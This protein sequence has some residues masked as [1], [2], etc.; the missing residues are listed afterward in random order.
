MARALVQA[1]AY[2]AHRDARPAGCG[3]DVGDRRVHGV[4]P[5]VVGLP[6]CDLIEQVRFRPAMDTRCGQHSV[7]KLRV[8]PSAEGGL[9]QE[10]LAESLQGQRLVSAG[11]APLQR[12]RREVKEHLA[13]KRV[14]SRVQG[15]KPAQ[16]LEDA[17]VTGEP[18]EQGMTGG[19]GVLRSRSLPARHIATVD[20]AE[21]A[22][23]GYAGNG[24]QVMATLRNLAISL[25]YLSGVTKRTCTRP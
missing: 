22:N 16:H 4:L 13:G 3:A 14:V 2:L 17:D 7:L 12:V 15:C 10:P 6:R 21:D 8:L 24:P 18:V 20:H 19:H 1:L 11:P 9:G 23:T 5:E 25:L